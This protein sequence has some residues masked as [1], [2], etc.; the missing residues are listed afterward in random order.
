MI[1]ISAKMKLFLFRPPLEPFLNFI[2]SIFD[3]LQFANSKM[4]TQLFPLVYTFV[5]SIHLIA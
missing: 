2:S 4:A 3:L 5:I 1:L